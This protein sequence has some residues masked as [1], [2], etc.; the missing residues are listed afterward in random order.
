[1]K[2]TPEVTQMTRDQ[3]IAFADDVSWAALSVTDRFAFQLWQEC[4]SMPFTEFQRCADVALA[5]P[6][7]THEFSSPYG[8]KREFLRRHRFPIVEVEQALSP[9]L[10]E[11]PDAK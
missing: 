7:F 1:M 3:A 4:L 11:S 9:Y 10:Q 6:V 8:L 5:R 2:H